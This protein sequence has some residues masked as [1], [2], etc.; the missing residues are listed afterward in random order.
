MAARPGALAAGAA[1]AGGERARRRSTPLI[2]AAPV[3]A[4]PATTPAAPATKKAATQKAAPAKRA[5]ATKAAANKNAPAKRA[6]AKKAAPA[7]KQAAKAVPAKR[8]APV[9][10]AAPATKAAAQA[11][12]AAPAVRKHRPAPKVTSAPSPRATTQAGER[13]GTRRLT[14]REKARRDA[15][16]RRPHLRVADPAAPT[17]SATPPARTRRRAADPAPAAPATTPPAAPPLAA[18]PPLDPTSA[19]APGRTGLPVPDVADLL[20]ALVVGLRVAAEAAGIAP[21]DVER[22]VA[23][24]LAY[25]RRRVEGDYEVDDFGYDE[26]FTENVFYPMLRPLYRHWFRVEVRGIENIPAE[27]GALVVSNHS[28]TVALDSLMVQLAIHDEHPAHRTM[29]ALGAD[30]VFRTPFVGTTARRSGSTLA[31]SEDAARL[32]G[33]G[34]LVGVFPEGFKGT[35][36]PF[37][38]RYKLQRFGRGGFV[39]AALAA[40]VPIVPCSVVGAE[41]TFPIIGNM[42]SLARLLGL[43][44]APVTPTFPWLGPLGMIPLPSKWIIEF[45]APID[46]SGHDEGA[47]DDP[48][49]VFDLTDQVRETIQQTLYTLLMQRRSVFF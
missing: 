36:K 1:R 47:A 34:E 25:L 29:R 30:L 4:A 5:T 45:G 13:T 40:G 28:G 26:H 32:F 44:Y 7:V 49:L 37:S 20:D 27:G 17:A 3:T 14:P 11:A 22:R 8:T 41:E 2:G 12:P 19:A 9:T 33:R 16:A 35:G 15:A 6:T 46:T 10:K 31:A 23:Q 48:M 39:S 42:G 24:V 18:V 38:E 43:P 21:E